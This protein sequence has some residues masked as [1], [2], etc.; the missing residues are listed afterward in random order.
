M[1]PS[2]HPVP[3]ADFLYW[4]CLL[5]CVSNRRQRPRPWPRAISPWRVHTVAFSAQGPGAIQ[6]LTGS[7][8]H[9]L[10]Q[11]S[12]AAPAFV[13]GRDGEEA[14]ELAHALLTTRGQCKTVDGKEL[15]QWQSPCDSLQQGNI[16]M[17]CSWVEW[18]KGGEWV[19]KNETICW[20]H[21]LPQVMSSTNVQ[22]TKYF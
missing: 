19:G 10:L 13:W 16:W 6:A 14:R 22:M 7:S 9:L 12:P 15:G 18:M 20:I 11:P 5:P 3:R 8:H 17:I 1:L 21:K 4:G 2:K